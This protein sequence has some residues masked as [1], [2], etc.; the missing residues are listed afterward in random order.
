MKILFRLSYFFSCPFLLLLMLLS[1]EQ[2]A[3]QEFDAP[4]AEMSN[5]D[6]KIIPPEPK[7]YDK[8]EVDSFLD[9]ETGLYFRLFD[10]NQSGKIDYMT[11][12]RTNSSYMNEFWNSVIYKFEYP[13]FY[14]IDRNGNSRFE[15]DKGE[16]WIDQDEDGLNGNEHLYYP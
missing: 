6:Y 8:E 12:T 4:I 10:M 15:P 3:A 2:S 14:W 16:M 11:A 5:D 9:R 13:L 1:T 7:A